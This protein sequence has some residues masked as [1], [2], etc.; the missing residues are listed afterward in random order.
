MASEIEKARA[1]IAKEKVAK[2]ATTISPAP[3]ASP[4]KGTTVSN[5]SPSEQSKAAWDK[6]WLEWQKALVAKKPTFDPTKYG[7]SYATQ[8]DNTIKS[9]TITPTVEPKVEKYAAGGKWYDINMGTD[10]KASFT[11][12]DGTGK[13]KTFNSLDEAKKA[14]DEG[15]KVTPVKPVADMVAPVVAPV[16]STYDPKNFDDTQK[17]QDEMTTNLND[18]YTQKPDIFNG[19]E[20]FDSFFHYWDERSTIQNKILDDFYAAKQKER[21]IYALPSNTIAKGIMDNTYTEWD[22]T[23]MKMNDPDKYAE[24]QSEMKK[25]QNKIQNQ[26]TLM[27][28][29]KSMW[30]GG[31]ENKN[32]IVDSL[33]TP[34]T[35]PV[36]AMTP[37]EIETNE[38]YNALATEIDD[39][40][41]SI[42]KTE[43][44][45]SDKYKWTITKWQLAS[46]TRDA[47]NALIDEKNDKILEAKLVQWQIANFDKARE[48]ANT[49][50][51]MDIQAFQQK[52]T[53]FNSAFNIF[54]TNR[55][56]NLK[57]QAQDIK[58]TDPNI[59]KTVDI[60]TA[61]KPNVLM[62][63]PK[64]QRYDIS[65][66]GWAGWV[67][68]E[69]GGS[70][71]GS[72]N[73]KWQTII[74]DNL[75]K[76]NAA[77]KLLKSNPALFRLQLATNS[78][79][80]G[81]YMQQIKKNL[82]LDNFR[83]QRSS[84]ASFGQMTN[85]EWAMLEQAVT[86]IWPTM[87][88]AALMTEMQR[89]A[90]LLGG[91]ISVPATAKVTDTP[92]AKAT[93]KA[94][95]AKQTAPKIVLWDKSKSRLQ[96]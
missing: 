42:N 77:A 93:V 95:L 80:V 71:G 57:E 34:P 88:D 8:A 87:S 36:T 68:Y 70:W 39:L 65:M 37:E 60:G 41:M 66:N 92:A 2:W 15:N 50:Y 74:S 5:F 94:T 55:E 13:I 9:D 78:W 1:R 17:R 89:I 43:K 22:L 52:M 67:Y 4:T 3:V 38:K 85:A 6:L 59:W 18:I 83:T 90:W 73:S 23:F 10:G 7:L 31:D 11:S 21:D 19:R 27:S 40:D 79:D 75:M 33:E 28:M 29:A 64:T 69:W 44:E 16:E 96:K 14:I 58:Q 62:W 51:N 86:S 48:I 25:E 91:A 76:I 61:K 46:L 54:N 82:T 35:Q 84:W 20:A 56:Y 53:L 47:T 26:E 63:N 30:L 45:I 72:M 12:Q 49:K 32:N 24:V 81:K